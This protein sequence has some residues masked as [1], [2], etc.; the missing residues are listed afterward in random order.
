MGYDILSKSGKSFWCQQSAWPDYLEVA[1]AFGWA[2]AGAFF[3][4]D[5]AG[6]GPHPSASY[7]GNDWQQVTDDDARAFGAALNLAITTVKAGSPLIDDQAGKLREFEVDDCDPFA[8]FDLTEESRDA[9]V[10]IRS[11][12]LAEHPREVRTIHTRCG[13]FDV[14][15]RGMI[16]LA[17]VVSAGGFT[18]A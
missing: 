8:D 17:D 15:L 4:N 5:E 7:L 10:K 9:L 13:S 3:K 2:P 11:L 18:I 1:I 14:N 6:F 12:Y 16:D